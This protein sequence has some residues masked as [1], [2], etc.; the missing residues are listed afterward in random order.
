MSVP[1][2]SGLPPNEIR[3][4]SPPEDPPEVKFR[5]LGFRVLDTQQAL[6]TSL[7]YFAHLPNRLLIVSAII[8]AVGTFVFT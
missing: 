4:D 8:I 6:S 7:S 1:T 2:P 5:F 3:A